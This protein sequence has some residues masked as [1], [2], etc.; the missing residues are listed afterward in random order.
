MTV[1]TLL[2]V[3]DL[4]VRFFTRRGVVQAVRDVTFSVRRGEVLGLVGESGSGKSVTSQAIMGLTELPGRIT[5]GD[6]RWKGRS[7]VQGRQAPAELR[8]VR[9]NE[10]SMVFQDPMTSLNPVYTIGNQL[11]EVTRRHLGYSKKQAAARAL[12]LLEL[13]GI[14]NPKRR[15]GQYPHE[16][17]GGMRQ[18]VL[19]AMALSCEPELLIADEPTT[20][21]DVTIQAQ[22]LELLAELQSELGL[23]V[24]L[25]THDLGVVAGMCDRVAVMYGGRLAEVGPADDMFAAPAHPYSDGLLRSTPRLD[26]VQSRLVSID[27]APPDLVAPPTGC[28]FA[29]R[30]A[31]ASDRCHAELPDLDVLAEG[32]KV[33]CWHPLTTVSA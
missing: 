5:G 20:A 13:V 17:S 12:E 32:R 7:L 31:H 27:G 21:L 22:I 2:D 19:I 11:A 6:V 30:C 16:F 33:A 26:E 15:L 29:P 24:L 10:I 18:R 4:Q 9:G 23:S 14:S 3:E 8:R 25:I 1:E 28:P